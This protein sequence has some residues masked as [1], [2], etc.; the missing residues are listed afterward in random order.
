[1]ATW[2]LDR[3]NCP[4]KGVFVLILNT[5]PVKYEHAFHGGFRTTTD[6]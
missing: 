5:N 1:M 3:K 4:V 2:N 6:S